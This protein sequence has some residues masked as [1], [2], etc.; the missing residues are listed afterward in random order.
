M[1][2]SIFFPLILGLSI[3]YSANADT[4]L[5]YLVDETGANKGK[6]ESVQIKDGRILVKS[7]DG[8]KDF[9]YSS[10][11]EQLFV[12]N[13]Q[14]RK[15]ITLDES[16]ISQIAKQTEAVQPLLQGVGEQIAKLNPKQRAKWEEMLGGKV[17]LDK[18]AAAAQPVPPTKI[19]KTGQNRKVAG[20]ACEQMDV[21]QDKTQTAEFCL[22]DP[23][24][25]NMSGADYAT[26]RSLLGFAERLA[27]KTQGL[28]KQFGVSI[29]NLDLRGLEGV[30]IELRD[31]SSHSQGNLRLS[32]IVAGEVSAKWMQAPQDYQSEPFKLWK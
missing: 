31:V 23:A 14:A 26:F 17:S 28:A 2:H 13:H 20:I 32:R 5:E 25:L 19:V 11:P 12:I 8:D 10:S 6:L 7:A 15:I 27:A 29:P 9:L 24:K 30:P 16:Q 22:A 3:V 1:R 4:A 18:I 21:F